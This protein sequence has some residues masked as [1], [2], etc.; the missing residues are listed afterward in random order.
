VFAHI[1]VSAIG[2]LRKIANERPKF[3]LFHLRDIGDSIAQH[4]IAEVD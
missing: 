1:V 3:W 4:V 2:A